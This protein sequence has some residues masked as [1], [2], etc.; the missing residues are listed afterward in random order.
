M[1]FDFII[2]YDILKWYYKIDLFIREVICA[3]RLELSFKM[4]AEI[5]ISDI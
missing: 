3:T 2:N 4:L 1:S 5:R